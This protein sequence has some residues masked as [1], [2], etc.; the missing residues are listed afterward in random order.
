MRSDRSEFV[1]FAAVPPLL[2]A[3]LV[4]ILISLAGSCFAADAEDDGASKASV[5]TM[6]LDLRT[7]Y[8]QVPAGVLTWNVDPIGSQSS[9]TVSNLTSGTNYTWSLTAIDANGN[10]ATNSTWYQP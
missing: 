4:A 2:Q 3:G 1:R 8:S 6:Y 7:I 9:T 5:P 10:Q